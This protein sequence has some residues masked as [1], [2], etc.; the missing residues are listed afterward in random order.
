[1]FMNTIIKSKKITKNKITYILIFL[2]TE[3]DGRYWHLAAQHLAKTKIESFIVL[4]IVTVF[5]FMQGFG[6]NHRLGQPMSRV[7]H[8]LF[9][10]RQLSIF[11]KEEENF[12]ELKTTN[13]TV[14]HCTMLPLPLIVPI[15]SVKLSQKFLCC[16]HFGLG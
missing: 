10:M 4:C 9:L 15:L 2:Q 6:V 11:G 8:R 16:C 5:D 13:G 7:T 3:I 12:V 1:M 14:R